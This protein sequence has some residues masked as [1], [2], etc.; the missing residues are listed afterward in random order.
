[1]NPISPDPGQPDLLTLLRLIRLG[2][3]TGGLPVGAAPA[4]APVGP[5]VPVPVVVAPDGPRPG[6]NESL[7]ELQRLLRAS[8]A[9]AVP[10][11]VL[12]D[13]VREAVAAARPELRALLPAGPQAQREQVAAALLWLVEN[14]DRPQV[15]A[16]GCAQVGAVLREL[17]V[18]PGQLQLLGPALAE[19]MR[20]S[21]GTHW[22]AEYAAA[23]RTTW[24]LAERWM[25]HGGDAGAYE[26]VFWT[27]TVVAH[28]RRMPDLAVLRIRPY[29]PYPFRAGQYTTVQ[30]PVVPGV[31]RS[32]SI[33]GAPDP[34]NVVELQ[35]RAKGA[36]GLS[37]ALVHRTAVGDRLR[38]RAAQG[39][40]VLDPECRRDLL[41]IAGDTGVAPF[42]ALLGQLA[43]TGDSRSAVLF[44]GVRTLDDLYDLTDLEALARAC[45]QA[46]VVPVVSD[47]DPGPYAGGL[48]TDAVEAYGQWSAHEVFLAGPPAMVQATRAILLDL[49]VVP[50]CI[51][52]DQP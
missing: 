39:A 38:L 6:D 37:G 48:V 23:W 36:E 50:D 41:F 33:A 13:R 44:W 1:M 40:L 4:P 20:A 30:S 52:H 3:L 5:G 21:L 22:R 7:S 42:K 49:G 43:D 24:R 12:V 15:V 10:V 26:P 17:N 47:G 35:V 2:G 19:A 46:T 25:A 16:A 31:W 51:H 28:E 29:L 14:L 34:D 18:P 32:Y 11:D 9:V 8:L 27:G 45:R